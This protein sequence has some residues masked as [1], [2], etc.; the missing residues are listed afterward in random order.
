[1]RTLQE[2]INRKRAQVQ[3]LLAEI[4][5][6]EKAQKI[7]EQE[8]NSPNP[9]ALDRGGRKRTGAGGTLGDAAAQILQNGPM[10]VDDM[11]PKMQ[12]LGRSPSK[13][14]LV[15]AMLKDSEKRFHLKGNNVFELAGTT[16]TEPSESPTIQTSPVLPDQRATMA[17]LTEAARAAIRTIGDRAFD[18]FDVIDVI[19]VQN[20][21]MGY[22]FGLDKNKRAS[23]S[24]TLRRL[25]DD[26][27]E[28][29]ILQ[30]GKG[31]KTSKYKA[32]T[33]KGEN[34]EIEVPQTIEA[35]KT[36]ELFE[37]AS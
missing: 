11:L 8:A 15:S 26:H 17:G 28:L 20:P 31:S 32:K 22:Q 7:V 35:P 29:E 23:L 1:M 21:A 25:A 18:V 10:H 37:Q 9:Q 5:S 12:E 24:G 19:K 13:P 14:T 33:T 6:L 34:E 36:E 16:I 2:L 4:E 30:Y 27:H 3:H